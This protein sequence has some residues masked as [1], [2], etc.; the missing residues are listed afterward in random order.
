MTKK[1]PLL[2]FLFSTSMVAHASNLTVLQKSL[3]D[4]API[5]ISDKQGIIEIVMNEDRMTPQIYNAVIGMGV[6]PPLWFEAKGSSYLKNTKEVRVLNRHSH[7]GFVL[8]SPKASC[9]EAG[10]AVGDNG[11]IVINSHTHSF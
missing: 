8:E 7:S 9:N 11:T 1:I 10:K 5:S 2:L 4:W 6:C 3:K